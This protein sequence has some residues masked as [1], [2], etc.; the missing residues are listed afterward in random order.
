LALKTVLIGFHRSDIIG[1]NCKF[2]QGIYEPSE[3]QQQSIDKMREA[4]RTG[5][6]L[7]PT[8]LT[9]Y[10]NDG[11]SFVNLLT[12]KPLF[13]QHNNYRF[14]VGLQHELPFKDLSEITE[15]MQKMI[16]SDTSPTSLKL[17]E[18]LPDRI[19]VD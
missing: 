17:L 12:M 1:R 4:L 13:D 6:R 8:L 9:N 2:L 14:V 7:T 10:R 16:M 3:K 19:F 11:S 15:E 18:I 5:K